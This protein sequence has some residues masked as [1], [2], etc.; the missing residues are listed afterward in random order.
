MITAS[1][2]TVAMC[3]E[4]HSVAV[5]SHTL[6]LYMHTLHTLGVITIESLQVF[7]KLATG[8]VTRK[9]AQSVQSG[10]SFLNCTSKTSSFIF[11][12][13]YASDRYA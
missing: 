4:V 7:K 10:P 1:V 5:C 9:S 11:M 6:R 3:P 2:L 8:P 13:N 12:K